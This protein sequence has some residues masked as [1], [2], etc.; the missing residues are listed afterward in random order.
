M[1][2]V[3]LSSLRKKSNRILRRFLTSGIRRKL[4]YPALILNL[5]VQGSTFQQLSS[6]PPY[7]ILSQ[8][9]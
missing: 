6:F 9:L 7:F 1:G 2:K 4:V 5:P 3:Y 8:P